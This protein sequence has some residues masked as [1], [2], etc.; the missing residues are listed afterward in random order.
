MDTTSR[1]ADPIAA[2]SRFGGWLLLVQGLYFGVL[3]IWP[4]LDIHSFQAV[5]G[6]KTDHLPT[7]DEN[8]HWLVITVGALIT[9]IGTSL[10]TAWWAKRWSL[11]IAV[12]GAFSA[13]A[14][15]LVDVVF[16]LRKVIAPIYI[17]DAVVEIAFLA[18]WAVAAYS[19]RHSL[20]P[21]TVP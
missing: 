7:G 8:D 9:V 20:P 10:L 11:E 15:A 2:L 14:L 13:L 6:P 16:V 21:G 19:N 4:I 17:A 12:L 3:G 1:S 5:T 18:C